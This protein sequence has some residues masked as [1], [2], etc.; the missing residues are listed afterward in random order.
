MNVLW[1]VRNQSGKFKPFV[2]NRIN[3]IQTLSAPGKQSHVK[4]KENPADLLSRGMS[5]EDLALSDL[6][7]CGPENLRIDNEVLVKTDIERPS[8]IQ[9]E[10]V[11]QVAM[12]SKFIQLNTPS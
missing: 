1:C 8:E 3:E 12:M 4:A 10:K 7:W 11:I 9:E 6:W 5:I 2:A